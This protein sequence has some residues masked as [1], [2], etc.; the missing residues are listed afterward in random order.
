MSIDA[1]IKAI[2]VCAAVWVTCEILITLIMIAQVF[3]LIP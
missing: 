1:C 2:V 3:G